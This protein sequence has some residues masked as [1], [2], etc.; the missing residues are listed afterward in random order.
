M[1]LKFDV[2]AQHVMGRAC[3]GP[4]HPDDLYREVTGAWTYR[5]LTRETSTGDRLRGHRRLRTQGL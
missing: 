4:F 3:A 5:K 2:L 1:V